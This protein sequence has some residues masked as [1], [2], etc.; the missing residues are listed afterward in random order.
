MFL[1]QCGVVCEDD[2][3]TSAIFTVVEVSIFD[4][5]STR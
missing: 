5:C 1:L 3:V 2:D 4:V